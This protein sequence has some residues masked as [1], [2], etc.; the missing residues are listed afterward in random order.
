MEIKN[1][2]AEYSSLRRR[3]RL[4][5][6]ERFQREPESDRFYFEEWVGRFESGH[7]ET[8]MDARS[9]EVYNNILKRGW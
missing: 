7:P 9:I 3:V 4:F 8:W 6:S 1:T 5:F 2:W